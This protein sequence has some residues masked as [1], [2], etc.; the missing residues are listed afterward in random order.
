M[1]VD[2]ANDNIQ[3]G[4][5]Q[6]KIGRKEREDMHLE[7]R[8]QS[9]DQTSYV[10]TE[11]NTNWRRRQNRC[12]ALVTKK[13]MKGKPGLLDFGRVI[14]LGGNMASIENGWQRLTLKTSISKGEKSEDACSA[15]F[16]YG[17]MMRGRRHGLI[18]SL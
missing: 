11:H 15:L 8:E 7:E 1:R 13:K 17:I 2:R 9:K 10:Q 3:G 12:Q 16:T 18:V 4:L 14:E 6:L 5:E